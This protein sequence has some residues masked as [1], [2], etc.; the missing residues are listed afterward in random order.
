MKDKERKTRFEG[1][2]GNYRKAGLT[3]R[4]IHTHLLM[5]W[6]SRSSCGSIG[7]HVSMVGAGT[8]RLGHQ[9]TVALKQKAAVKLDVEWRLLRLQ[10]LNRDMYPDN[11][12]IL[13]NMVTSDTKNNCMQS[14]EDDASGSDCA[15]FAHTRCSMQLS[16]NL[17]YMDVQLV[18]T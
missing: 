16:F 1:G 15:C 7:R 13:E 5:L 3:A 14:R 10:A 17:V 12:Q 2:N 6:L 11:I 18:W 9:H 8:R 4:M